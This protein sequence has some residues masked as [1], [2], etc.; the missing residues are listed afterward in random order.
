VR[1]VGYIE[2]RDGG[3]RFRRIAE[4]VDALVLAAV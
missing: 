1:P 2:M 4:P 3:A